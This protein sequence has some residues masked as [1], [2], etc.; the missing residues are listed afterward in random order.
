MKVHT[1]VPAAATSGGRSFGKK[2]KRGRRLSVAANF[3]LQSAM[4]KEAVSTLALTEEEV[5]DIN[6][7]A[8]A[9]WVRHEDEQGNAYWYNEE[10]YETSWTDP[11]RDAGDD[12]QSVS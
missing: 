8:A 2:K 11:A 7:A 1:F 12:S 6:A 4:G 5:D 10:T 9:N 3:A